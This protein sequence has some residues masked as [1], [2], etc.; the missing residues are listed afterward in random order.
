MV[1]YVIFLKVQFCK[2]VIVCEIIHRCDQGRKETWLLQ[3]FV[4]TFKEF[5]IAIWF[6]MLLEGIHELLPLL[7]LRQFICKF[8]F[9]WGKERCSQMLG[10]I[11]PT[12]IYYFKDLNI[13]YLKF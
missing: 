7:M 4:L 2:G 8:V 12:L 13:M 11:T 6:G 3:L 10:R 9:V 5:Q 1:F